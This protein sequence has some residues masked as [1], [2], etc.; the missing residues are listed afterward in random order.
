MAA[1][2]AC[3]STPGDLLENV[4]VR[5]NGEAQVRALR[6]V[7]RLTEIAVVEASNIVPECYPHVVAYVVTDVDT[8]TVVGDVRSVGVIHAG[9]HTHVPLAAKTAAQIESDQVCVTRIAVTIEL[10][11]NVL[12]RVLQ[13]HLRRSTKAPVRVEVI[14]EAP[15]A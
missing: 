4:L 1:P 12:E 11:A 9:I 13:R 10:A 3:L 5:L 6:R 8:E 15:S 7:A 14:D 2:T